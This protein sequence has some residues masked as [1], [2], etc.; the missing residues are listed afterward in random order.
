[1]AASLVLLVVVIAALA[2]LAGLT[3]LRA[4][5][6]ENAAVAEFPPEGQILTVDGIRMHA[7]VNGTGPD[8]VLIHGSSGSTRDFTFGLM[9]ELAKRYRVIAIDRP[10]MGWSEP[11]GRGETLADQARL[12]QATAEALGAERP[13]VLGQ[14][15]GGAVA[16]AWALDFP[17]K[18][19]ALVPVAAPSHPWTT[20]LGAY[21]TVL[22]HPVGQAVAVPLL[23]AFA[24][25][26]VVRKEVEAVFAPQP[27][28][29]GYAHH[30]A[31]RLSL[32]RAAMRINARMRKALHREIQDMY[33]RY[34]DITV[35]VEIVHGTADDT[36]S[37]TL[38]SERLAN[39]VAN[40]NLTLLDGVGHMPHHVAM[41]EVVAAVD[42]AAARAGLRGDG[43]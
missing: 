19:A 9:P 16:L 11:H 29:K 33:P 17:D 1:M 42:R 32:R 14:S 15:Y 13:I 24:P 2:V 12:L 43:K 30:F 3:L 31:A 4:N 41:A 8:V 40:A 27:A 10:G 22:S 34:G 38:H 5:R 18:I 37:H 21:Y 6:R 7:V 39:D 35:P 28:P 23:T 20:G 26:D 36:V 25:D